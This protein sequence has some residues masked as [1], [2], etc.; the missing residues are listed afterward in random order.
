MRT[1]SAA[2]LTE[3]GAT[4]TQPLYLVEITALSQTYRLTTWSEAVTWNSLPW[5][6]IGLAVDGLSED[7]KLR[8]GGRM[9]FADADRAWW[10]LS[11]AGELSARP[12]KIWAAYAGAPDDA[13]PRFAGRTGGPQRNDLATTVD[14]LNE[15]ADTQKTPRARCGIATGITQMVPAG[16]IFW[17]GGVKYTLERPKA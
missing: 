3:I 12:V 16:T 15:S 4:Y 1:L 11:L 14:L 17:L 6:P 8:R 13:V 7:G 5:Q 9:V 10:I 2:L